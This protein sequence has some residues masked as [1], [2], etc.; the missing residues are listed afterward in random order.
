MEVGIQVFMLRNSPDEVDA[1]DEEEDVAPNIPE[2]LLLV[3][4]P[5]PLP[6]APPVPPV[7]PRLKPLPKAPPVPPPVPPL[8]E[9]LS[10]SLEVRNQSLAADITPTLLDLLPEDLSIPGKENIR[11]CFRFSCIKTPNWSLYRIRCAI[12]Y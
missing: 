6:K 7:A 4:P 3:A 12:M 9:E 11:S 10:L 8:K 2:E 5:P 1:D